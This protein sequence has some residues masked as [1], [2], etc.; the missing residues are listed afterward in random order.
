MRVSLGPQLAEDEVGAERDGPYMNGGHDT[1]ILDRIM[2]KK[3]F[4]VWNFICCI[5][6]GRGKS[7]VEEC[8]FSISR[9]R[10]TKLTST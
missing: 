5:D 9:Q 8:V 3:N 10:R 2:S 4:T 6:Y 1:V 7:T